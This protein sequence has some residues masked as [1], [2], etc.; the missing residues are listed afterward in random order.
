MFTHNHG[1]FIASRSRELL[2]FALSVALLPVVLVAD[3]NQ[4]PIPPRLLPNT[5]NADANP[6]SAETE[7]PVAQLWNAIR[8]TNRG[9]VEEAIDRWQTAAIDLEQVDAATVSGW[10]VHLRV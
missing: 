2:L 6:L 8:T 7:P 10:Q 4:Q 9:D 5:I 3:Q 1:H